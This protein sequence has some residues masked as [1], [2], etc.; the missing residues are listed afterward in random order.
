MES[1]LMAGLPISRLDDVRD[2]CRGLGVDMVGSSHLK[3]YL[4]FL[5]DEEKRRLSEVIGD[6]YYSVS[7]DGSPFWHQE[8]FGVMVRT[9]DKDLNVVQNLV[10][11]H[12]LDKSMGHKNIAVEVGDTLEKTMK[13]SR[14]RCLAFMYDSAAANLKCVKEI[15]LAYFFVTAIGIQCMSHMFNNTGGRIDTYVVARFVT[16]L[17]G[18]LSQS[19]GNRKFWKVKVG[20]FWKSINAVRW[21]AAHDCHQDIMENFVE[22]R[23]LLAELVT[24]DGKVNKTARQLLKLVDD[25]IEGLHLKLQ[26]A[27]LCDV[28]KVITKATY[29]LE[30][31]RL[32]IEKAWDIVQEVVTVLGIDG[33][34]LTQPMLPNMEAIIR[35]S[36]TKLEGVA[37]ELKKQEM[38]NLCM[39]RIEDL[40]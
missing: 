15:L 24:S 31:D 33:E 39:T 28:G 12:L 23:E 8:V 40:R 11:L 34:Q 21:G 7:F 6:E 20:K 29:A 35:E 19:F 36:T 25:P 4:E 5:Q 14:D 32:M 1:W 26:L 27:V 10:R 2:L 17:K 16:Q 30:S 22:V 37:L 3:Q 13:L 9:V 18:L 38:R